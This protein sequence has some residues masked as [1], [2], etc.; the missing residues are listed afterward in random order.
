MTK[1]AMYNLNS[2]FINIKNAEEFVC[3]SLI[4]RTNGQFEKNIE[5]YHAMINSSR[6]VMYSD[7]NIHNL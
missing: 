1:K 5:S 3:L 7:F 4:P 6:A 2:Y